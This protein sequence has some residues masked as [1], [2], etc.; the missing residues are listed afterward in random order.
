M[1]N[2]RHTIRLLSF[3][4][5]ALAFSLAVLPINTSAQTPETSK[6]EQTDTNTPASETTTKEQA[7]EPF[8]IPD[9]LQTDFP[10][11]PPI[12]IPEDRK[13]SEWGII[14]AGIVKYVF[15]GI[16]CLILAFVAYMLIREIIRIK[17]N[18]APKDAEDEAPPIPVYQP[19]AET[20]RIVLEDSDTLAAQGR[21]AEAVHTLLFRSIQDIEDK[22]PHHVNTSLTSREISNLPILSQKARAGFSMISQL[23]E[24]S[25]FGKSDL[26]EDDYNASKSAYKS[27]AFEK[28]DKSYTR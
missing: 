23:V 9:N 3:S 10:Q 8:V 21:Y 15:Y 17:R 12:V 22:R 16:L 18:H 25:F 20:A 24:G 28:I 27:F 2:L 7:T 5:I 26:N 4:S 13:T 19:D 6:Q 11:K 1:F 14:F